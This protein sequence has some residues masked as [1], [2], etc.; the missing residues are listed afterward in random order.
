MKRTFLVAALTIA[1]L[2]GASVAITLALSSFFV[3]EGDWHES[4]PTSSPP[5]TAAALVSSSP[6]SPPVA[7]APAPPGAPVAAPFKGGKLYP[8]ATDLDLRPNGGR[9]DETSTKMADRVTQ[10]AVR[11]ALRAASVQ[12]QLARCTKVEGF[13]GTSATG[14]APRT[15]PASLVLE[16]EARGGELRVVDANVR[17][18]GGASEA[19]VS[20]A[21]AVLRDQVISAPKTRLSAGE[22]RQMHFRL[23]PRR[24][25]LASQ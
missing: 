5:P 13:G 10:R 2:C 25:A 15:A 3:V 1:V 23:N 14:P 20:C 4:G 19:M 7:V 16:L 9:R 17:E 18:W 6:P 8:L 11:K 12:S 21:R 22:R 24:D